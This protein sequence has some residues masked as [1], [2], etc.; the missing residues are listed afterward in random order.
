MSDGPIT[1]RELSVPAKS[2]PSLNGFQMA[3]TILH[4]RQTES[5]WGPDRHIIQLARSLP[6]A[7]YAV[8]VAVLDPSWAEEK[9]SLNPLVQAIVAMQ[10]RSEALPARWPNL[11]GLVARLL[12]W[13][14]SRSIRLI[15]SHEFKTQVIGDWLSQWSG[16][17]H[18]TSDHGELTSL[19][20]WYR[21]GLWRARRCI[22]V[23]AGSADRIEALRR[24]GF[25]AT[26]IAHCPYGIPRRSRARARPSAR[27]FAH[28]SVS[29]RITSS[30]SARHAWSRRK[31]RMSWS[32]P[33][34]ELSRATS[35]CDYGSLVRAEPPGR[36][37]CGTRPPPAGW[38]AT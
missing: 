36:R 34:V 13:I 17:P 37:R 3:S 30:S 26:Q 9:A 10:A 2:I 11:A 29:A 15:H 6:G 23:V 20:R 33:L 27:S 19:A 1:H 5:I 8:D 24:R 7:G 22:R 35:K 25:P 4:L 12:R 16:V 32:P 38:T 31:G 18:V 14:D 21:V 28:N